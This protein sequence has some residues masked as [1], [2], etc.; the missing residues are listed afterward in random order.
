MYYDLKC[1]RK[2]HTFILTFL[3]SYMLM[4]CYSYCA[5]KLFLYHILHVHVYMMYIVYAIE[6][7]PPDAPFLVHKMVSVTP[8]IGMCILYFVRYIY[9]IR[10]VYNVL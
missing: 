7:F 3:Y 5:Y 1:L 4:I 8:H 10:H 2:Y 9:A 6:P